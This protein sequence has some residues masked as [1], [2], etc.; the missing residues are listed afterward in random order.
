[1][2]MVSLIL[3]QA[4]YTLRASHEVNFIDLGNVLPASVKLTLV[5]I[6]VS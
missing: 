4:I 5:D 3:P 6:K 1:M 2:S